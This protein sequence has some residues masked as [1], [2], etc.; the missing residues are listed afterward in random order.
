MENRAHEV[1]VRVEK[2]GLRS[3]L[4]LF[5]ILK[6]WSL[7]IRQKADALILT[8]G[9]DYWLGG[10]AGRLAKILLIVGRLGL[11]RRLE[12]RVKNR[13]ILERFLD[14]LVVNA[15]AIREGLRCFGNLKVDVLYNG[16][17][18][19]D[20]PGGDGKKVRRELGVGEDTPL[21]GS[22]GRLTGQKGMDIFLQTCRVLSRRFP[23]AKFLIVGEGPMV[24]ELKAQARGLGERVIFTGF[25]PDIPDILAALDVVVIS[26][27][28][29]GVPNLLL[30]AMAARRPIVTTSVAGISEAVR[31][32]QEAL[33][34]E[35]LNSHQLAE[36]VSR[37]LQEPQLGRGLGERA[38][39]KAE[40]DFS[41]DLIIKRWEDYLQNEC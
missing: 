1:G 19:E 26:S 8:R 38:Y 17:K 13:L 18:V 40:R 31:D 32:G 23:Q 21:I 12:R 5:S 24:D 4:D 11:V 29:E 27:R 20:Y 6:L 9:R 36:R 14:R 16:I 3:D 35:G 37:I 2:I 15:Q 28:N 7:I 22:I 34:V 25:R 39:L 10:L 30:E 41:L 33:L